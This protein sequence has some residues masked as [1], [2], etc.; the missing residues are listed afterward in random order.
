MSEILGTVISGSTDGRRAVTLV[1]EGWI[2]EAKFIK[3]ESQGMIAEQKWQ[4][5][6]T[7]VSSM[8]IVQ[9]Y[10]S[11]EVLLLNLK[12]RCKLTKEEVVEM[13]KNRPQSSTPSY[14]FVLAA[15]SL[16]Y[17]GR[18][19]GKNVQGQVAGFM[20]SETN[21]VDVVEFSREEMIT[22]TITDAIILVSSCFKSKTE[23][24][25]Y[26]TEQQEKEK[27]LYNIKKQST[28]KFRRSLSRAIALIQLGWHTD[29]GWF[30]CFP[31]CIGVQIGDWKAAAEEYSERQPLR[32]SIKSQSMTAK[33]PKIDQRSLSRLSHHIGTITDNRSSSQKVLRGSSLNE[34]RA[35]RAQLVFQIQASRFFVSSYLH[36]YTTELKIFRLDRDEQG[37]RLVL[38]VF[39]T[40]EH[41]VPAKN[42]WKETMEFIISGEIAFDTIGISQTKREGNVQ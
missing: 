2:N 7:G 4:F 3:L 34:K 22:S 26:L 36:E 38:L 21:S 25:K 5:C 9:D 41:A 40:V 32:T 42:S 19:E 16:A 27:M 33:P 11:L 8:S 13:K 17:S 18:W 6:A 23:V 29:K 28:K 14:L 10:M 15:L 31:I 37:S 35:L 12:Q 30:K 20:V 1:R 24:D 39:D